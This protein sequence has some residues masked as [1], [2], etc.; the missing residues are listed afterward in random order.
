MKNITLIFLNIKIR[1][2]VLWTI[3]GMIIPLAVMGIFFPA[4]KITELLATPEYLLL[5]IIMGFIP[6]ALF[7]FTSFKLKIHLGKTLWEDFKSIPWK[8]VFILTPLFIFFSMGIGFSTQYLMLLV[9]P[10][11]AVATFKA[12]EVHGLN[13]ENWVL[14]IL[15]LFAVIIAA[16]INEE[17]MFRGIFTHRLRKHGW[18]WLAVGVPSIIFGLLHPFDPLGKILFG[19]MMVFIYLKTQN[20]LFPWAIHFLNNAIAGIMSQVDNLPLA[21]LEYSSE[22]YYPLLPWFGILA[23]VTFPFLLLYFNKYKPQ[24]Q[25]V[26]LNRSESEYLGEVYRQD[27]TKPS[28]SWRY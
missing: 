4:E 8:D 12:S 27:Q 9:A 17:L 14:R 20:I 22:V 2:L 10:E 15:S 23:L 3:L 21:D 26:K 24:G 11:W 13:G 7:I 28:E 18:G 6:L 19:L 1:T 16:P 5:T 25:A